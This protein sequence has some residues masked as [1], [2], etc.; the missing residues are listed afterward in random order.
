MSR[1]D[2][3]SFLGADSDAVLAGTSVGLVGLGGGG[4]HVAQQLAH[5]GVGSYV[6]LDPD[7]IDETNLN[8]LVG[9]TV[10][11][12]KVDR[13]KVEIAARLIAGVLPEAKIFKQRCSWQEAAEH[14]KAVD[15][16][17]GGV[18]SVRAKA[19]MEDFARRFLIPYI[20]MGMDVH[21]LDAGF[22][23]AGQVVLSMPGRPCLRCMGLVTNEALEEEARNY[24]AAGG[25]PQVVWPNGLLASAAVGL[26]TQL[27]C[28]WQAGATDSAY[29]EYDGN[30]GTLVPSQRFEHLR[31]R[32]CPH[33]PAE[34]TGDPG[35]DIRRHL[36]RLEAVPPVAAKSRW[37]ARL[38]SWLQAL[39]ASWRRR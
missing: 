29:L 26:F 6:L 31:G 9:G 34:A 25:K 12:V 20:D 5:V 27:V 22:L 7:A 4:S 1:F 14:L 28:P 11:D 23:V 33:F 38:L 37:R 10:A 2:R 18:D 35:F 16:I 15:V 17:I 24:G 39:A 8:R 13:A 19:E 32:A 36:A 30:R 3:Q 21:A